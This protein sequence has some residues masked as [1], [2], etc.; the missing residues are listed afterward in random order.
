MIV[1]LW[2]DLIIISGL[3]TLCQ[4][5]SSW[6]NYKEWLIVHKY[7]KIGLEWKKLSGLSPFKNNN[8]NN[9]SNK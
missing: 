9:T 7:V 6:I 8:N 3:T 5:L 1:P 4:K 2:K